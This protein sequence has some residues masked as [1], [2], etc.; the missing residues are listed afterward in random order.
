VKDALLQGNIAFGQFMVRD[1]SRVVPTETY[2]IDTDVYCRD[3]LRQHAWASLPKPLA[4]GLETIWRVQHNQALDG[5]DLSLVLPASL[6]A[7]AAHCS[8][9]SSILD[10]RHP[11]GG[12]LSNLPQ[13]ACRRLRAMKGLLDRARGVRA[14]SDTSARARSVLAKWNELE[15]IQML[16]KLDLLLPRWEQRLLVVGEDLQRLANVSGRLYRFRSMCVD[17]CAVT[18]DVPRALLAAGRY[19]AKAEGASSNTAKL[20]VSEAVQRFTSARQDLSAPWS[21]VAE[22]LRALAVLR[23]CKVTEFVA[24]VDE[25]P[26]LQYGQGAQAQLRAMRANLRDGRCDRLPPHTSFDLAAI[27]PRTDDARLAA[28]LSGG[29]VASDAWRGAAE[30]CWIGAW[31]GWRASR[32]PANHRL[33][34]EALRDAVLRLAEKIPATADRAR[35]VAEVRAGSPGE[36]K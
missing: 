6:R 36:W 18:D 24:I 17:E 14:A 5:L 33:E 16:R 15:P 27:S 31:L 20:R 8:Y 30:V 35:L 19:Y 25:M 7:R 2:Y 13:S 4:T 22:L 21:D 28:A 10:G 26:N 12:T 32:T 11:A 3:G 23:L 1:G 9:A 29:A 34:A